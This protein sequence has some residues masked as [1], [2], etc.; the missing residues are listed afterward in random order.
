M[1]IPPHLASFAHCFRALCTAV[2]VVCMFAVN[3]AQ[4]DYRQSVA[5]LRIGVVESHPAAANPIKIEAVKNAFSTALGI[6]VEIIRMRSYAALIDAHAS[7]RIGYAIHSTRSF[8]ATETVC[9]CVRA[10]RTPVA[11]DGSTGFRSVLVVRDK[12][13]KPISALKVAY[14]R[15]DSVSGWRIPS[16]AMDA[17]S[18]DR[19]QLVRAGSI[20][21]VIG[22]YR[23][24]KVDGFF[25]WL[26]DVP[27]AAGSD[28]GRLFGGWN[29]DRMQSADPL[30]VLWSSQRVPYGPHA[31]HRSL[32]DDLVE[33]LGALL[34]QMPT[35]APGLLD[36]FEPF[37]AGGYVTPD[38]QDYR[39]V[40]GL[41]EASSDPEIQAR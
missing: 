3:A 10:L 1:I 19:P 17:G 23:S 40:A 34:D 15:A 6:P 13:T 4:A 11:A 36:I 39:N 29:H 12:V 21:A 8:V 32:P 28:T 27:D 16:Q 18:L 30:R 2:V 7:G 33:A 26:P 31:V 24:G 5:V 35:S 22:L 37:F 38:P 25:G 14:S 20:A 9:G 41:V